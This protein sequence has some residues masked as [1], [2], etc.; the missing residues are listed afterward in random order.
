[1]KKKLWLLF[2]ATILA[3]AV[4]VTAGC[5]KSGGNAQ[6][7]ASK[8]ISVWHYFASDQ[9]AAGLRKFADDFKK[10]HPDVTV[11]ITFVSREE[12]MNQYTVGAVSG[13]LPDIGMVDS[14]DHSSYVALGVFAD[15]TDELNAW[16]SWISSTPVP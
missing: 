16:E 2:A 7:P 10:L 9:E 8:T 15:I 11:D 5:S 13:Q 4:M 12:L 1:M 3:C 6:S 14:P